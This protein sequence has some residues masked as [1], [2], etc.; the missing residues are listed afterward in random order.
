[1]LATATIESHH[2][3][4]GTLHARTIGVLG[5]DNHRRESLEAVAAFE[6]GRDVERLAM[7]EHV[8][9]IAHAELHAEQLALNA[10]ALI[11]YAELALECRLRHHCYRQQ[12]RHQCGK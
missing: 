5:V 2:G 8:V 3:Y 7:V 1:M 10:D 11:A 4:A 12:Q 9:V 6:H